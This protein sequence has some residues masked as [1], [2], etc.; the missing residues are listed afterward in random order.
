MRI[1]HEIWWYLWDF[2]E[3]WWISWNLRISDLEISWDLKISW[4]SQ[5][6]VWYTYLI[7]ISNISDMYIR[8]IS[9][10][11]HNIYWKYIC[12]VHTREISM[13]YENSIDLRS[14]MISD[15]RDLINT[16]NLIKI[17]QILRSHKSQILDKFWDFLNLRFMMN[18]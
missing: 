4:V 13:T 11:V 14:V 17:D 2:H 9:L 15:L 12:Y 6:C 7:Y 10:Y 1:F 5:I 3:I 16:I 8:Y 18:F